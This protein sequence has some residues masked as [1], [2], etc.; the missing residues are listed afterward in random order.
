MP[1]PARRRVWPWILLGSGIG[2]LA[3]LAV[4]TVL[5]LFV[6]RPYVVRAKAA[7]DFLGSGQLGEP[8]RPADAG[9]APADPRK[10]AQDAREALDAQRRKIELLLKS[11]ETQEKGAKGPDSEAL[12]KSLGDT[13][14]LLKMLEEFDKETREL[15]EDE[16]LD[17]KPNERRP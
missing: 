7:L 6:L 4:A 9:K 2:V 14:S 3:T 12:K 5:G 11:I 10:Q 15:L 16:T 17:P 1:P 8:Q 13:D